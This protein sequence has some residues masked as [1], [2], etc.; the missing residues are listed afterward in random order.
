MFTSI[1][2]HLKIRA[3]RL[4]RNTTAGF[5]F[6]KETNSV[7]FY[8]NVHNTETIEIRCPTEVTGI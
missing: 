4:Q 6:L 8:P 3:Q 5:Q 1:N 7:L 2:D